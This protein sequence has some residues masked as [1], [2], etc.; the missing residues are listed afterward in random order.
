[1]PSYL[2]L[3]KFS[4]QSEAS[5][6][7]LLSGFQKASSVVDL[8]GWGLPVADTIFVWSW[9]PDSSVAIASFAGHHH[10]TH[11]LL[12]H[13]K[14]AEDVRAPRGGYLVA[15]DQIPQETSNFIRRGRLVMWLEPLSPYHDLYSINALFNRPQNELILEVVGPGFDASDLN[16][17]DI[18]PHESFVFD[19]A[20]VLQKEGASQPLDHATVAPA[21]YQRSV[22]KRCIK[23]GL[24]SM[25]FFSLDG[26]Q[27]LPEGI[28]LKAMQ[29]GKHEVVSNRYRLASSLHRYEPLPARLLEVYLQ[30]IPRFSRLTDKLAVV[31]SSFVAEERLIYW[32]IVR[33]ALKYSLKSEGSSSS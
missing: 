31:S 10:A 4:T 20:H 23:I 17:G 2:E 25:G 22:Q 15:L 32:D 5:F 13:D 3:S 19:L 1:M 18:S 11:L 14:R 28:D 21:D 27:P 30:N 7:S 29:L 9:G 33:P 6:R 24:R 8:K 26:D 12:R 16:R